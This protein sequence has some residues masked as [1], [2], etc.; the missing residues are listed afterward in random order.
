MFAMQVARALQSQIDETA[1]RP[2]VAGTD[3]K[4]GQIGW[5]CEYHGMTPDDIVEAHSHLTLADV[6][7]ALAYFY[8]HRD[9]IVAEW[10]G[11]GPIDRGDADRVPCASATTAAPRAMGVRSGLRLD[12]DECVD[13]RIAAGLRRW[14]VDVVIA[15]GAGSRGGSAEANADTSWR[16]TPSGSM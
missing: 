13:S 12:A 6:N 11:A 5:E 7:A 14:G 9:A 3:I 1:R 4:V 15:G 2:V 16:T 10:Q 8:D